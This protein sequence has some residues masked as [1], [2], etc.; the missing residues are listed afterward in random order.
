M[1]PAHDFFVLE[2][3]SINIGRLL[4]WLA[5]GVAAQRHFHFNPLEWSNHPEFRH[6]SNPLVSVLDKGSI[7]ITLI[8]STLCSLRTVAA[9]IVVVVCMRS[10]TTQFLH[11]G[12]PA[13]S[14]EAENQSERHIKIEPL[15]K[16]FVKSILYTFRK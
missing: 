11:Q 9:T 6:D 3:G 8:I 10:V 4:S 14:M 16:D 2:K 13:S 7:L 15:V 12:W 5:L 1:T